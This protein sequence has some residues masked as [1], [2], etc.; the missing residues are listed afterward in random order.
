MRNEKRTNKNV[1]GKLK[2]NERTGKLFNA[3]G[4]EK[5]KKTPGS[6]SFH[7]NSLAQE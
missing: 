3:I 7:V 6:L 2:Q 5:R 4:K 1:D